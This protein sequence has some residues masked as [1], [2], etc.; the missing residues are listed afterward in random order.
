MRIAPLCIV[1]VVSYAIVLADPL[2]ELAVVAALLAGEVALF[3]ATAQMRRRQPRFPSGEQPAWN[4]GAA[5][6]AASRADVVLK[7]VLRTD[8]H[9]IH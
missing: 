3:E 6:G 8:D 2:A 1:A 5:F 9:A 7:E 4:P